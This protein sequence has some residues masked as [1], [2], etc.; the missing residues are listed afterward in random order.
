[1]RVTSGTSHKHPRML[2]QDAKMRRAECRR[3]RTRAPA[4][5]DRSGVCGNHEVE[6]HGAKAQPARS[7]QTMLGHC[8]AYPL[9][10]RTHRDH[11]PAFAT[12]SCHRNWVR[13]ENVGASDPAV[14]FHEVRVRRVRIIRS[15][16]RF[17]KGLPHALRHFPHN[18]APDF[19]RYINPRE[20]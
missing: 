20:F 9:S 14:C 19:P 10:T 15:R 5:T 3:F 8:T 11:E 16:Q 4:R 12:T 6:L 7:V 2:F 17:R 18:L 13:P 1:M